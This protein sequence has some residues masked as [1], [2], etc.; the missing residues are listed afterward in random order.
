MKVALLT[1]GIWP[2]V[3]GGMQKH[4][5]YLCKYLALNQIEVYL[6]HPETANS[7]VDLD[8]F[9]DDEKKFIKLFIVPKPITLKFPGHYIYSS[10]LFS[11]EIYKT[12]IKSA[13]AVD[14]IIAKGF[15]GWEFLNKKREV[16]VGINIHGYEFAQKQADIKSKIQSKYLGF[17]LKIINKKADYIFS[18]GGNITNI[19]LSLGVPKDKIIEIPSGIEEDYLFKPD[20]VNKIRRFVFLGR[21]ERRK[22]IQE[23]TE[24]LRKFKGDFV[25]EFIGPIPEKYQLDSNQIFYHGVIN[26]KMKMLEILKNSDVLVCPSYSEGMPNVILEGMATG[27]AILATNVGA[28]NIMVHEN[29]GILLDGSSSDKILSALKKF[30]DTEDHQIIQMKIASVDKIKNQFLWSNIIKLLINELEKKI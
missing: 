6:F 10:I 19:I 28:V 7:V 26:D 27:N 30:L 29:N 14:F 2:Y 15:T 12:Y 25:F 22:G 17:F 9:T 21:W 24:A 5:Y 1:D 23:L 4:S 3:I 13:V 16:P 20:S 8:V 18:Y 11:K